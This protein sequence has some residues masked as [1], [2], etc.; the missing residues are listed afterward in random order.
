[1]S[2]SLQK[3]PTPEPSPAPVFS[4]R[5]VPSISVRKLALLLRRIGLSFRAGVDILKIWD[6]EAG[7]GSHRHREQMAQV[8]SRIRA[9]D[10]LH[11]ALES[12]QGYFPPLTRELVKVGERAGR[13]DEVLLRLA[14]HY[15]HVVR[16]RREFLQAVAWPAIQLFLA[17]MVI[18]LLI[19]IMGAVLPGK[20][21]IL[22][23]GL[24]GT[25]GLITYLFFVC[26]VTLG[27]GVAV[28]GLLRGW[29]GRAPVAVAMR[30]WPIGGCLKSFALARLSW[31]LSLALDAGVSARESMRLAL[32]STQNAYYMSHEKSVDQVLLKGGEFHEA[33]RQTNAFP[34]EFLDSLETAELAGTHSESMLRLSQEYGERARMS[35]RLLTQFATYAVW[36]L[37]AMVIISMIFRL[38]FFYLGTINSLL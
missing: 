21:D 9:G 37:V 19:W 5:I 25:A 34:D 22:G 24:M 4:S 10:S 35:S 13:L 29:F 7:R 16:L 31:S 28:T 27:L 6:Q 38:A 30:L 8:A 32:R 2:V 3:H 23:F 18:G 17:V 1:M 20:V 11:E 33:L 36:L 12:C 26:S 15:D 14:D